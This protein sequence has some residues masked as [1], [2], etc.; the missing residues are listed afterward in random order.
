MTPEEHKA[1]HKILHQHLDELLADYISHHPQQ[2]QFTKMPVLQLIQWS[3]EQSE[4]PTEEQ[5]EV[6]VISRNS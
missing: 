3:K 1:R 2:T 5:N 6:N 4:N